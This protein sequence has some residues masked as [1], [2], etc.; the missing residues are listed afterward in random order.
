MIRRCTVLVAI[1]ILI[2]GMSSAR[3]FHDDQ[4]RYPR[5]RNA[6][7]HNQGRIDSLYKAHE[8]NRDSLRIFLR[9]LKRER[10]LELWGANVSD[11]MTLLR[12]YRFTAYC[13]ELGPKRQ[14]GDLQIPEGVYYIDRFNPASRLHLSLGINYPNKSDRI[15]ATSRNPGGDI[16]IH[17]NAVT[18]GCIPIGDDAIEELYTVAVDAK[19]AGQSRIPVHIFPFHITAVNMKPATDPTS[20]PT[21]QH[22]SFWLEL[23][24]IYDAFERTHRV[25][26]V[27]I[28]SAGV[29]GVP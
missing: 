20:R 23:K 26:A 6:R 5:V 21:E 29:Y 10:S 3:S 9:A 15:R 1:V 4:Q 16:F 19:S 2:A 17:G 28:D 27:T 13:G 11:S 8:I 7:Q 14:Q 22:W 24:K 12:S 25:P 18:I